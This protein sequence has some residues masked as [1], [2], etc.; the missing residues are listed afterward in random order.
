MSG[1]ALE[2]IVCSVDSQGH[3]MPEVIVSKDD[4]VDLLG[5]GG[6]VL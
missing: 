1:S 2:D 5:I 4:L 6:S 3:C